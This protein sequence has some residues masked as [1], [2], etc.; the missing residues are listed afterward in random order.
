MLLKVSKKEVI[1]SLF[2]VLAITIILLFYDEKPEK[3]NSIISQACDVTI[4]TD[5]VELQREWKRFNFAIQ[6]LFYVDQG[7]VRVAPEDKKSIRKSLQKRKFTKK[8]YDGNTYWEHGESGR[9]L[10]TCDIGDADALVSY[11]YYLW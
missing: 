1:F 10:M 2:A 3:L 7:T 8:E 9:K 5:V 11:S 6:G 4:T